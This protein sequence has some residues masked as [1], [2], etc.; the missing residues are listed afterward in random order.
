M[1]R[2][3]QTDL[4]KTAES[5][6]A[7]G[8]LYS[9]AVRAVMRKHECSEKMATKAVDAAFARLDLDSQVDPRQRI[10]A[11]IAVDRNRALQNNDL[12]EAGKC[13]DRLLRL[14]R[15]VDDMDANG[16]DDTEEF[17]RWLD[18]QRLK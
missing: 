8:M 10:E 9:Q 18:K 12:L 14:Y 11:M 6:I 7:Q 15:A 16:T 4:E 13:V 1:T 17:E 3:K 5:A 2:A